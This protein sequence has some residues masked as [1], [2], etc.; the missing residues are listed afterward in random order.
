[1]NEDKDKLA[2][3]MNQGGFSKGLLLDLNRSALFT[4]KTPMGV[5][6]DL[7]FSPDNQKLA[8]TFN[9]PANPPDI[10]QLD[11]S[12]IQAERLTY[13]SCSSVIRHKLIEPYLISYPSFDH[14]K[15]PAFYYKPIHAGEKHPVI[16]LIHG[17]PESQIRADY[18]P[19]IQ[20]FLSHGFA[21]CTPNVR[22]STGYGKSYTHLDDTR[23]RMNAVKD[24]VYLVK[25]LSKYG[26]IDSKKVAIMGASYGGF[27]TL[28]AIS[29]YPNLWSAAID[30]VGFSSIKKFLQ[31]TNPLRRKLRE[32]EYGTI[33]KDG[34]FFDKI[35]PLHHTDKITAPLMVLHG[36]NDS[37]VSIKESEQI[38]NLLEKRNHPVM[39]IR[40]ED[41]G[42]TISKRK[43]KIFA[44]KAIVHFLIRYLGH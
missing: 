17:G 31:T 35:D 11:L 5:I 34:D 7:V 28:A 33:E 6:S 30:M 44:Y 40:F 22:G 36:V 24:L 8:Y 20:Y 29:H 41:E 23:K 32:D 1:M 27:L 15:V 38:V 14:L 26:G 37:R 10:W 43:N 3:T 42:H 16:I 12:T 19:V 13:F 18:N 4:W 25:W 21:V 9:G 39:F 2:F